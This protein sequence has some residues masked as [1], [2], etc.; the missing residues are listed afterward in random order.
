MGIFISFAEHNVR[1]NRNITLT[2]THD[3]QIENIKI[4]KL[5]CFD[6]QKRRR[7][8]NYQNYETKQN[9][10]SQSSRQLG[11]RIDVLDKVINPLNTINEQFL[12]ASVN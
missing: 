12:I 10:P 2:T 3:L 5:Y 4:L 1:Q 8:R 7:K 6:A 9:P 11:V